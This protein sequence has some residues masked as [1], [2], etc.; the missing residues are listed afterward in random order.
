M[1][2][3]FESSPLFSLQSKL[4]SLRTKITSIE[5]IELAILGVALFGFLVSNSTASPD[6]LV[7]FILLVMCKGFLF[8]SWGI[9]NGYIRITRATNSRLDYRLRLKLGIL[10]G[11]YTLWAWLLL[12]INRFILSK[13]FYRGEAPVEY[14]WSSRSKHARNEWEQAR[15]TLS[16]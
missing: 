4:Q 13:L 11:T 3:T 14:A 9:Y 8:G 15:K 5:A 2:T 10:T 7:L 1:E 6:L 12:D 16:A